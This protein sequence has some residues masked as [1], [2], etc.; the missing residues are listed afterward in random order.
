MPE[1]IL[2]SVIRPS[3]SRNPFDPRLTPEATNRVRL[4]DP[5]A[6]LNDLLARKDGGSVVIDLDIKEEAE[7]RVNRGGFLSR[8]SPMMVVFFVVMAILVVLAAVTV[9]IYVRHL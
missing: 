2:Q 1:D 4:A 9:V 3:S 6:L 5:V 7:V 8:V